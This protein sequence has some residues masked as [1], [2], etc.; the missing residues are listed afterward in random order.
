MTDS[1]INLC[2]QIE[3]IYQK[4]KAEVLGWETN[5]TP[6]EWAVLMRAEI[7]EALKAYCKGGYGRDSIH[8]EIL[9][10]IALGF[11]ALSQ[12]PSETKSELIESSKL[13]SFANAK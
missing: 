2:V 5:K 13:K 1:E 6:T 12:L 3:R 7:E 4:N 9:Q 11:N 8:H 10:V